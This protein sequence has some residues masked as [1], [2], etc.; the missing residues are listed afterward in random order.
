MIWFPEDYRDDI[1]LIVRVHERTSAGRPPPVQPGF[2]R[3]AG[4]ARE[5]VRVAPD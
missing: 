4:R 2:L 5:R 1:V 3:R